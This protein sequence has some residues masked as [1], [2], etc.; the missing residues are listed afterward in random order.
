MTIKD[1][2]T[3]NGNKN[4]INTSG[5]YDDTTILLSNKNEMIYSYNS[6]ELNSNTMQNDVKSIII[7][8]ATIISSIF[9]TCKGMIGIGLLTLPWAVSNV[10]LI[11]MIVLL[12]LSTIASYIGW[13]ILCLGCEQTYVFDYR[14]LGLHSYGKKLAFFI[15]VIL[16]VFLFTICILYIV[17]LGQFIT[18]A[19]ASFD[20]FVSP[21]NFDF[22]NIH[23]FQ[24]LLATKWFILTI[25]QFAILFPLTLLP[26][27]N[28]LSWTSFIGLM[29]ILY[30]TVLVAIEFFGNANKRNT[31]IASSVKWVNFT[32]KGEGSFIWFWLESFACFSA[33]FN[34][35]FNA[36]NLYFE[37]KPG[38]RTISNQYKILTISVIIVVIFDIIMAIFGYFMFGDEISQNILDDLIGKSAAGIARFAM[39]IAIIGTFPLLFFQVKNSIKNLIFYREIDNGIK[40]KRKYTNEWSINLTIL[41]VSIIMW[42]IALQVND[43]GI[44]LAFMQSILGNAIIYWVPGIIYL[45]ILKKNGGKPTEYISCYFVIGFGIFCSFG[46]FIASAFNAVGYI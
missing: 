27:L 32:T 43:V 24:D 2:L 1:G 28:A 11:P 20:I 4:D 17:F 25:I 29:G 39:I 36:P 8:K 6:V 40:L 42:L 3:G 45:K 21:I 22:E 37:L 34:A 15:D 38:I 9:N 41:C 44:I 19:L 14:D 10:G 30:T 23:N 12:T 16:L 31:F 33:S 5:Y 46:G 35:H 26:N 18:S 13:M 7:R